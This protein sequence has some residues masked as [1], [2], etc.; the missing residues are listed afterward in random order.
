MAGFCDT[1]YSSLSLSHTHTRILL[2]KKQG[3]GLGILKILFFLLGYALLW[4]QWLLAESSLL[5]KPQDQ[6]HILDG[7]TR[8]ALDEVVDDLCSEKKRVRNKGKSGKRSTTQV[9]RE[10]DAYRYNDGSAGYSICKDIYERIVGPAN[11][12]RG[13]NLVAGGNQDELLVLHTW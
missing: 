5:R 10:C 9:A 2:V 4:K 1:L 7:L 8:S 3:R 13:R 11:V 12:S 6:I